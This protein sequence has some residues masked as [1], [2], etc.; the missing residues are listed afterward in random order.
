MGKED[1]NIVF[2]ACMAIIMLIVSAIAERRENQRLL[3]A[4]VHDAIDEKQEHMID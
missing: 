3:K 4:Q 2:A 1:I